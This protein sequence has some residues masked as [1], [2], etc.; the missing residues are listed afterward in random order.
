MIKWWTFWCGI[1]LESDNALGKYALKMLVN[2]LEKKPT[3]IYDEGKIVT[4][5]DKEKGTFTVFFNR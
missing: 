4:T 5:E 2:L 1:E 3:Q